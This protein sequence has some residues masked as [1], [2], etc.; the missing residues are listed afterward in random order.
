MAKMV[1]LIPTLRIDPTAF[2]RSAMA[3]PVRFRRPAG[4]LPLPEPI[5]GGSI[6]ALREF[7][8]VGHEDRPLLLGFL[9][10]ALNP[11]GP[12]PILDLFG[13]QGSAK[14]TSAK[15]IRALLD[16]SVGDLRA[17]PRDVRDLMIAA[18]NSWVLTFDNLSYLPPWLADALCR[19]ST[20]GA[21]G[22][23]QLYTDTDE[24]LMEARRPV[25]LTGI[26][27]LTVRS[28]LADRAFLMSLPRIDEGARRSEAEFWQ[29][30]EVVKPRI[31]GFHPG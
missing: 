19:L 11:V 14:S 8:N 7:V 27:E 4:M 22:A 20:G 28:D 24:V 6:D 30:F 13:E 31:R 2:L 29:E 26:E 16:P 1:G 9:V 18:T 10:A 12:Y 23:R 17:E 21:M 5:R 3:S 25:I 15:V